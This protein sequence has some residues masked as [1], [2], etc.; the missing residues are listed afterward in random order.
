MQMKEKVS[1]FVPVCTENNRRLI[2]ERYLELPK[3][4]KSQLGVH[5]KLKAQQVLNQNLANNH[6]Q[7][8][9]RT[10]RCGGV[11]LVQKSS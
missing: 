4:K 6:N 8:T 1:Q 3:N 2:L 7:K 10:G 5:Q 9:Y 11:N